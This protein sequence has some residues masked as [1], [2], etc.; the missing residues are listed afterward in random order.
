MQ[1]PKYLGKQRLQVGW[2]SFRGKDCEISSYLSVPVL[3]RG[4]ESLLP[5][6]QK[7]NRGGDPF[8][9]AERKSE[10][11]PWALPAKS[12]GTGHQSQEKA[13]HILG[14]QSRRCWIWLL[15]SPASHLSFTFLLVL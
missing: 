14:K 1:M 6:N 10:A 9:P 7:R 8:L 11:V 4:H 15:Q 13:A 5:M 12:L 3:M 2:V